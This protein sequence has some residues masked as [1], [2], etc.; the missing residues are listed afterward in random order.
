MLWGW[1]G[2]GVREKSHSIVWSRSGELHWNLDCRA[3]RVREDL[4]S[5]PWS[6]HQAVV[7]TCGHGELPVRRRDGGAVRRHRQ[8]LQLQ[9]FEPSSLL[10]ARGQFSLLP[11]LILCESSLG[12]WTFASSVDPDL[13]ELLLYTSS[14][15]PYVF[16]LW[17]MREL[18]VRNWY[19]HVLTWWKHMLIGYEVD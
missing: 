18:R 2:G 8:L 13:S 10:L 19:D 11:I 6:E 5:P 17:L 14:P 4:F 15:L 16:S 7:I 3:M 1:G 9:R 12:Q